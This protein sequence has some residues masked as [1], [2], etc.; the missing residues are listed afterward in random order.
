MIECVLQNG[1]FFSTAPKSFL[2]QSSHNNQEGHST[3]A[4]ELQRVRALFI[5]EL[6]AADV[7][8]T[9]KLKSATGGDQQRG[10]VAYSKKTTS[11]SNITKYVLAT[12]QVPD[13]NGTDT[14][15][16]D[17][18]M[19]VEFGN[20]F[21]ASDVPLLNPRQK[22]ADCDLIQRIKED[23]SALFTWFALA[24]KDYYN[25][26]KSGK[27]LRDIWPEEWKVLTVECLDNLVA[28]FSSEMVDLD[29]A[30]PPAEM[31]TCEMFNYLKDQFY[32]VILEEKNMPHSK[33]VNFNNLLATT[34]QYSLE[35]PG[36][37]PDL[38]GF[39]YI[40]E[41]QLKPEARVD[42]IDLLAEMGVK[43]TSMIDISDGLSSEIIHICKQSKVG[44]NLYEEKIPVDPQFINV[45]EEFN[46]DST[47]V[48]INGGEDYE[49][50]FTIALDD[51]DKI[52]ANPNF[53]VIGHLTQ[54]SEGIHLITRANTK[55]PLK[56]RG[57][58]ALSEE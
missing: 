32:T 3:M 26:H 5:S 50:L 27:C 46:I 53:T 16:V 12:N 31:M 34:R 17:R 42:I 29:V 49:L 36:V 25:L 10:R 11:F 15:I 55:I 40:L 48:T 58:N 56:A 18:T 14:A 23:K 8:D 51:F 20:R 33:K 6:S 4:M 54:E 35:N 39:D 19:I 38:E 41:R 47:T 13:L 52:K 28:R 22:R 43:P 21:E 57:W 37:Q 45:C 7:I 30:I 24:A 1:F 44:C 9:S 2:I